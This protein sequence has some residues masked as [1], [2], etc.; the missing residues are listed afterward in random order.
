MY[1]CI[2]HVNLGI[3]QNDS[4][5]DILMKTKNVLIFLFKKHVIKNNNNCL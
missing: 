3:Y 1:I 5:C 4:E 2:V